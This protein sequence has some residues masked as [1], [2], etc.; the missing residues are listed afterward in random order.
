M[1]SHLVHHVHRRYGAAAA[2]ALLIAVAAAPARTA[3]AQAG[4]LRI[5]L[6]SPTAASL[7][8]YADVPVSL[9]TG[10]PEI[11]IPL[12]T[13]KGRTLELPIALSY[14]AGG[15]KVEEIGG[16]VGMGWSLSAGGTITR[17]VRGVVDERA[18]GYYHTG[19]KLWYSANWPFP[20]PAFLDSLRQEWVDAEPDQFFYSFAGRSGQI[21]IGPTSTSSSVK[22]HRAIPHQKLR[23]EP[24][25]GSLDIDAWVITTEDGTRYTFAAKETTRD[26]PSVNGAF[27]SHF[28]EAYAS[29]WHLTEIKSVGGDVIS[30]TYSPYLA[31]H[32]AS[33]YEETHHQMLGS[34]CGPSTF[35]ATNDYEVSALRLASITSA[36]HTVT[37]TT[38]SALRADALSPGGTPQEPRLERMTVKTPANVVLRSFFFEH[39]YFPGNRLRLKSVAEQDRNGTSLPPH[40]FTYDGQTLPAPTSYAQDHWGFFNAKGNSSLLPAFTLSNGTVVSGADREPDAT[41]ARAGSLTKITYPT[42]GYSEFIYEGNDYGGIGGGAVSPMGYGPEKFRY[43]QASA[44]VPVATD[45]FTLT[46][47]TLVRILVSQDPSEGCGGFIP[48]CP[49]TE[50]IYPGGGVSRW[51]DGFAEY[52]L[53]LNPGFYTIR[54]EEA[55][56]GGWAEIQARWREWGPVGKKAGGGLRVAELRTADA[57]GTV[58]IRKFRYVLQSDATRSSGLVSAEPSY[59]FNYSSPQCSYISRSAKSRLPLGGGSPVNYREVTVLHGANG[60]FGSTRHVFRSITS[61]PDDPPDPS[62]WPQSPWTMREGLRGQLL[63]ASEYSASGATQRREAAEYAHDEASSSAVARRFRALSFHAMPTSDPQLDE[64]YSNTYEVLSGWVYKQRDT[65]VAYDTTGTSSFASTRTYVHGTNHLQLS[66]VRESNSDGAERITFLRYPADYASGSGNP[67]AAALSLMQGAAHMPGVVVERWVAR[68]VG[69]TDSIVQASLTMFRDV[70]SGRVLPY[71]RFELASQAPLTNFVPAAVTS[72]SFQKDSRYVPL[73]TAVTYDAFG[74]VTELT[75]AR[76]KTTTYQ[77]GGNVNNAFL[78]QVRRAHDAS[79]P[80]DLVTNLAYDGDGYVQSIQDE[81]GSFQY[82]TYDLF[83]R[84]RQIKNNAGTVLEAFGYSYSRTSPSWTFNAASPNAV[85]DSTFIQYSPSVKA[86]VSTQYLD[87]LGRPIQTVVQDGSSY[88]V[89]ATQYDAMGRAWRQWKPYARPSAGYDPSFATNATS[90]YNSYLGQS[91][92]KPYVETLYRSEPASRVSKIIPEY[93]GSTPTIAVQHAYGIDAAAKQV[94]AELADESGKKRR[95]VSDVFGHEVKTILGYGAPEA[96]TTQFTVDILGHRVKTTDPRSLVTS[97]ALDT[98]GLLASRVSPD[99][100]TTSFKYDHAG[101]A[102]YSQD[103]KQAAAGK[104]AFT[105]YDFANRPLVSGEGSATFAALDPDAG[106]PPA[107]ETTQGNW[108]VV[109]QYDGKPSTAAF[110]W[111]RFSAQ[112]S[113]L[114]LANVSGRLAAIASYSNGAWQATLLSYDTDGR[115]ATRS[116]FTEANAGTAVLTALNTTVTYVRDLRDAITERSLTVGSNAFNHWYEYD[117]RGL[118]WKVFAS[119][120][121]TKPA[122]ADV[123]FTYRPSGQVQDRQFPGGPLVPVRYTIREQLEKIGDPALTS[124]PFSARYAY[125]ANGNVSEAEFYSAGSPAAQKRYK[126]AF[127]TYDAL[128]RLRSADFSSWNGSAWTTTLA[129]DLATIGYDASGNLTTLQRYRETGTLLDNLTYAYPGSSNRLSSVSDAVGGTAESWD[130]ESGAFTYDANGNLLTAPAPYGLSAVTYDERNLP[131]TLTSNGTPST[132]R[133]DAAG[134][135][136]A[137]RVGSGNTEVYVLD[138]ATSLGVVTVDGAG[139]PVS[140]HFNVLA[141][142]RVM[143]RQPNVGNRRYYHADLL[144]STRAVVDG[145]TVLESY[146]Y[147]PMGLLMPGRTLGTGTKEGFTGKERD[148]ETGLDYFGARYYLAALGR[149]GSVDPLAE[150]HPEWSPYNYVLENP[151]VLVDPDGQQVSANTRGPVTATRTPFTRGPVRPLMLGGAAARGG[152]FVANTVASFTA[153]STLQDATAVVFERE[154]TGEIVGDRQRRLALVGL[155]TPLSRREL[156]VVDNVVRRSANPVPATM[157][158]VIPEGI[159]TKTL[160]RPGE[161][162]VFVTAAE[163]IA[164]M[165][166]AE[167]ANRLDIPLNPGGFRVVEF[168]TPQSGVASPILRENPGF[169]G[170]GRTR[171]GAREFVIPNTEIPS[172]ATIRRVPQ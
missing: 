7:G 23:I 55:A 131:L 129:H 12:V 120:G 118:L 60:E 67:E 36:T 38:A 69:S 66:E 143:G 150:K 94:L 146:D 47:Q 2:M 161:P 110:P 81:G 142:D 159:P 91:L 168:P 82:F 92:A 14:H 72:G 31:T 145:A 42:G 24:Q 10:T 93:V 135:R 79:G 149:W 133:Y 98:R 97:Y 20:P 86:V 96:T 141:G 39:D 88:V 53:Q 132:Y 3:T 56:S 164:G 169:V 157:A 16:W 112:I 87:G 57:M 147:E 74:R 75:D 117:N 32:R 103:A 65:T 25:F 111:S 138:G 70:G 106:S 163:D 41:K 4:S 54:A 125:H 144:G 90:F 89:T 68:R 46:S 76:G 153:L 85:V 165:N 170:R 172:N 1:F 99:A 73:E 29:S 109:R 104:V 58:S 166:A 9:H 160:G 116:T 52:Q 5:S 43:A 102:R 71:Q 140:W 19:N 6:P 78:T 139:A 137:K 148:L 126:Y 64:Y 128:N 162:D 27:G 30:F 105:T 130:A 124:Y 44:S 59:V 122:T 17:S 107:L 171:G 22:E 113:P 35:S 134:Q 33:T 21:V 152:A 61:A 108:R 156:E 121:S 127:P 155:L 80:V 26:F 8:K 154:L 51:Y 114:A 158:R 50:L 115:V 123:T 37:F 34:A 40:T 151:M 101:N 84:L 167:I 28:G 119:T 48:P 77:F 49:Y 13:V 45:T 136:I 83:G 63:S 15:L 18:N 62:G 95:S 11:T 100:G